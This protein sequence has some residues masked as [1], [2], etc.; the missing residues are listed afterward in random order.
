MINFWMPHENKIQFVCRGS[1][2][3]LVNLTQEIPT[4]RNTPEFRSAS[5]HYSTHGNPAREAWN[6][7]GFTVFYGW[8]QIRHENHSTQHTIHLQ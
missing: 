3:V 8:D 2:M 6:Y 1:S 7:L 5:S 4:S